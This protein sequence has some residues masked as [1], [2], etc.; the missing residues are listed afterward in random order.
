MQLYKI[1]HEYEQ[2]LTVMQEDESLTP[3]I[4]EDSLELIKDDFDTKAINISYAIKNLEA[5]ASAIREAEKNMAARRQTIEKHYDNIKNY[6]LT[7]MEQ[8]GISEIKCPHFAVKIK[9]C[10][11]SVK[12][13]ISTPIYGAIYGADV[14]MQI[15]EKALLTSH[16]PMAAYVRLSIEPDK[17][18]MKE[19]LQ[20]GKTIPDVKL[21]QKNRL[22]IK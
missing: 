7:S 13:N 19:A 15:C 22:E 4:I 16:I 10:P 1:A 2:A 9:K 3:E 5:E 11:P 21:V 12:L 17:I 6:L 14:L 18:K 8:C 20:N